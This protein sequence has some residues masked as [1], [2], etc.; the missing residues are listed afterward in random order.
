[1]MKNFAI[2][3]G[4]ASILAFFVACGGGG[5]GGTDVQRDVHVLIDA[6]DPGPGDQGQ[7]DRAEAYDPGPPPDDGGV[8]TQ[9]DPY[10]PGPQPDPY[11]PGPQPD[12]FD[13]GSTDQ[14]LPPV[15]E[16]CKEYYMCLNNCQQGDQACYQECNSVLSPVGAQRSNALMQCLQ[17]HGCLSKPTDQEFE[18]CLEQYCISEYFMCFQGDT[19]RTCYDLVGCILSCPQDNPNTPNV[20][21]R[22]ECVGNCWSEA[23]YDAQMDLQNLINCADQHCSSQ[24]QDPNAPQCDQCWNQVLGP[25]GACE[26]LYDKCTKY[27]PEGCYYLLT[28]LNNCQQGD[29]ACIQA[30]VEQTSKQGI[31]LYNA[32]YDCIM[33]ACPIC[34]TQPDSQQCNTCFSQVQQPGGACAGALQACLDDRPYGTK[35]CGEL[36]QCLNTCQ[37]DQA[38]QQCFL[39]ATK[40]ANNLFDAMIECALNA[41]RTECQD[42]N[43]QQCNTCINNAIQDPAKCKSQF[44]ACVNDQAAQ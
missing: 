8:D 26:S 30:C 11:D 5:G 41:C 25:G 17:Q 39:D 9:P 20:D 32:I 31:A 22:V 14:G 10:D 12:T 27:G 15:D 29:N 43:S 42:P 34:Q 1:M 36:L 37:S 6:V 7:P 21:E 38:C 28:C 40:T 19:Y 18:Q 16:T 24:C 23:T 2:V 35:K 3:T 13:P 44:D 33:Q 4:A